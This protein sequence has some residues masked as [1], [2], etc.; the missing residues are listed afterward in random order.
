M[1]ATACTSTRDAIVDMRMTADETCHSPVA[2]KEDRQCE[3]EDK[4]EATASDDSHRGQ[5]D[6]TAAQ[7]A[8]LP[9]VADTED[10]VCRSQ[11]VVAEDDLQAQAAQLAD[12]PAEDG[13]C[14][15]AGGAA[16]SLAEATPAQVEEQDASAA[17]LPKQEQ[18]LQPEVPVAAT[19]PVRLVAEPIAWPMLAPAVPVLASPSSLPMTPL[20][21]TVYQEPPSE[22]GAVPVQ[23][24][25]W[26]AEY[27][28]I[29]LAV[30][31]RVLYTAAADGQRHSATV[32]ERKAA[33]WVIEFDVDSALQDV[34]DTEVWRLEH[35]QEKEKQGN[36]I[37]GGGEGQPLI[38][39]EGEAGKAKKAKA[40]RKCRLSLCCS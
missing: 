14:P 25:V 15:A 30:G 27:P 5:L 28:I 35:E 39:K 40:Q 23:G 31:D 10:G 36:A 17:P 21:P 20:M 18:V 3:H 32:V 9:A 12:A 2:K 29:T 34:C 6:A 1:S 7:D 13:S 33:S 37:E 22:Y 38:D 8:G 16:E 4:A 24:F 19:S 11:D 26:T